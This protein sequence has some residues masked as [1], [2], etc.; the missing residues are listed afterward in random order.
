MGIAGI[1]G[2][3]YSG[4]QRETSDLIGI[5]VGKGLSYMLIN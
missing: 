5:T 4:I 2:Y 1:Q 3:F